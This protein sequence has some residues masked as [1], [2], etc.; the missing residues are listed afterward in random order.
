MGAPIRRPERYGMRMS[1]MPQMT[2]APRSPTM[3]AF[4]NRRS[5]FQNMAVVAVAEKSMCAG[6]KMWKRSSKAAGRPPVTLA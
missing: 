4:Q 5:Y 6:W 1:L 3:Q 2:I